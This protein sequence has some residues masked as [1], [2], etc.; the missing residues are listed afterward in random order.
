M[1]ADCIN[2]E[3][4]T[5]NTMSRSRNTCN[6]LPQILLR[7]LNRCPKSPRCIEHRQTRYIWQQSH[8]HFWYIHLEVHHK[9][10]TVGDGGKIEDQVS[11]SWMMMMNETILPAVFY[12]DSWWYNEN[13]PIRMGSPPLPHQNRRT[14]PQHTHVYPSKCTSTKPSSI[15]FKSIITMCNN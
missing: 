1:T 15:R 6:N 4:R 5:I 7:S 13:I 9:H 12:T 11:S 8:D 10:D 3:M 14:I 2:Q